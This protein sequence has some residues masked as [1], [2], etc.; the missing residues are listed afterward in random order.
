MGVTVAAAV[1]GAGHRVLWASAGRSKATVRRAEQ[2]GLEDRETLAALC[3]AS[4]IVFS[5]CPPDAATAVASAVAEEGFDGIFVDANAVAPATMTG[6]AEVVS[7]G[8]AD[9]VDGGIVGPPAHQPGTTRLYLSGPRAAE[10]AALFSGSALDPQILG[11]EVGT[12]SALKMCYAA[13]T[14]GSAALLLAVVAL[15]RAAGVETPLVEEWGRSQPGLAERA[16]S[17]AA[18]SAP[19][20]WRWT[21]EM[22]EIATTFEHAGLPDGF[23]RAAG[24]L[25]DRLD[26]FRDGHADLDAVVEALLADHPSPVSRLAAADGAQP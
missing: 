15:A 21:G 11:Q 13:Y 2:A 7:G 18:G 4:D 20:A 9:V 25:F 24:E 3:A 1:R 19:K 22:A 10:V 8:G 5:V 12:A 26:R 17:T 6:I 16:S 23:H 14:K